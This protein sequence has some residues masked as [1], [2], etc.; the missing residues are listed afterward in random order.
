MLAASLGTRGRQVA[1][2][3]RRAS[4]ASRLVRADV[5]RLRMA[6]HADIER[7]VRASTGPRS[8]VGYPA[9]LQA[10]KFQGSMASLRCQ[11]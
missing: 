4:L 7:R 10:G 3:R 6:S 11:Q 2:G 8:G 9:D 5:E 1:A